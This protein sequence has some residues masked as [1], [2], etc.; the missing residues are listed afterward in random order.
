[1]GYDLFQVETDEHFDDWLRS[2]RDTVVRTAVVDR[3]L[4]MAA[5]H[6]GDVVGLGNGLCEA[7]IHLRAG[8]R[9]YFERRG[10][11]LVLLCGG[12]KSTQARD[13]AFARRIGSS[14]RWN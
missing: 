1:M 11:L 10:R 12:D 7:R 6:F 14:A 2:L 8:Y 3:V 5:G 9:I 13:I 4:R